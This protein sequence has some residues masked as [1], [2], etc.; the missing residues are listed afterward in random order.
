MTAISADPLRETAQRLLIEAH[1]AERNWREARRA[2]DLYRMLLRA[3]LGVEPGC[4]L[5]RL[6]EQAG[7]GDAA[8]MAR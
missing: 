4:A 5:R 1:L 7:T 2:F 6:L 3:E 8:V